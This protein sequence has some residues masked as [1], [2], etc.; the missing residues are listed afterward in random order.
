[1]CSENAAGV[2]AEAPLSNQDYIVLEQMGTLRR[3][4]CVANISLAVLASQLSKHDLTS[5]AP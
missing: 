1:M 2:H 3:K 4:I 5:W